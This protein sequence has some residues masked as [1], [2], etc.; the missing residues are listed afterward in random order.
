MWL[1]VIVV[2]LMLT[3]AL[4]GFAIVRR[5]AERTKLVHQHDVAGFL[6]AVVGVIYAVLLAFIVVIQWQQYSDAANIANTE[7][8]AVGSLYRDA[9]A[10]GPAGLRLR[11]VTAAYAR[12][13]AFVE[14][15]Y[16]AAHQDEDA[17]TD[18]V[19]NAVWKGVVALKT[20]GGTADAF[21]KKA[22]DD[23]SRATEAR[24][25]RVRDSS[26]EL[27]AP[28]W[29][30]LLAG[31]LMTV[32]FCYF[33]SLESFRAQAAMLAILAT[34]IGLSLFVILTL[35]L[36]FTGSVAVKPDAMMDELHEFCS[37]NFVHPTAGVNC[38]VARP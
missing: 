6:I 17:R 5:T 32:G 15:P 13:V 14:W 24:R 35:D 16:V 23:L 36:P 22:V 1:G 18:P 28:L 38:K 20:S 34:L 9:V 8:S 12:Q 2:G 33:F 37:Y 10:L 19:R 4:G 30:V 27:P 7:A 11:V 3:I 21:V 31:A 25:A 29:V 26:S